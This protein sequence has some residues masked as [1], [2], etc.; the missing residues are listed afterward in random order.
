MATL[1]KKKLVYKTNYH[2]M[3]VKSIAGALSTFIMLPFDIKILV[4]SLFEW[5]FYNI[6]IIS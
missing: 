3:Q 2:L 6:Y 4:L 1:K 5:L